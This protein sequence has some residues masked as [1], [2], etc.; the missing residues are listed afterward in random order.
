V[1]RLSA[2]GASSQVSLRL[3]EV[4]IQLSIFLINRTQDGP[5]LGITAVVHGA[6]F[7]AIAAI[8]ADFKLGSRLIDQPEGSLLIGRG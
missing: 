2:R 8:N 3:G 6:E 4:E 7:A 1:E 5:P